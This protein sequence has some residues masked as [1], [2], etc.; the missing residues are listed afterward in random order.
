MS[1]Q[2]YSNE[3]VV[4]H[5]VSAVLEP[6]EPHSSVKT[7]ANALDIEPMSWPDTVRITEGDVDWDSPREVTVTT[8]ELRAMALVFTDLEDPTDG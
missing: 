6:Y 4:G 7:A 5:H 1:E 2:K 3:R 8:E